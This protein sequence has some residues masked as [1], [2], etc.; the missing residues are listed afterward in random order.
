MDGSENGK[1]GQ[2]GQIVTWAV[3]GGT[4]LARLRD[5]LEA[6]GLDPQ[7]AADLHPRHLLRRAL[8]DMKAGRVICQLRELGDGWVSFQLTK[9]SAGSTAAVYTSEAVVRLELTTGRVEADVPAVRDRA[10]ELMDRHA[11]NREAAD[12]TRLLQR[13]YAAYTADLIPIR[14]QGGAYFVP[15]SH[16]ALVDKTRVLL[17]GIGGKLRRFAVRLGCEDTAASVAE[18][19]TSYLSELIREF[20]ESCATV[21]ADSRVDVIERRAGKM[22]A[23]KRRMESYRG[24]LGA[25]AEQ[26][27]DELTTA[28]RELLAHITS[29]RGV[30]CITSKG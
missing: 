23:L 12:L 4:G 30:D 11:T 2:L 18:S 28:E 14:D 17:E 9:E 5:A 29:P 3:P 27:A 1:I 24:L 19:L 22:T 26:I 10:R 20:R 21:T 13:I 6:A 7:M 16:R 8:R 25:Y 15:D